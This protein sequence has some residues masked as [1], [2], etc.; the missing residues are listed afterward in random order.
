[1]N[2]NGTGEG[3]KKRPRGGGDSGSGVGGGGGGGSASD[4][5]AGVTYDLELFE[6]YQIVGHR[7]HD[8]VSEGNGP[9]VREE[10]LFTE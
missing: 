3:A 8:V 4:N 1:M 2:V 7:L 6:V 5:A 9:E 10:K